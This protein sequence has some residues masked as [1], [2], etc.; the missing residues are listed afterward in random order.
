MK[1]TLVPVARIWDLPVRTVTRTDVEPPAI[2]NSP[3]G[4]LRKLEKMPADEIAELF[5][6]EGITGVPGHGNICPLAVLFGKLASSSRVDVGRGQMRIYNGPFHGVY[7]LPRSVQDFVY[8]F[9]SRAWPDLIK[10][11]GCHGCG[12]MMHAMTFGIP[13]A[14][15]MSEL[16]NEVQ[17][18]METAP[19]FG[20]L[21]KWAPTGFMVEAPTS[22]KLVAIGVA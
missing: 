11:G 14:G 15:N 5:R 2:D 16:M 4:W 10:E 7:Q 13:V 12:H 19:P 22:G 20:D 9:D 17:A 18:Y 3:Q 21:S 1:S 8:R 6:K